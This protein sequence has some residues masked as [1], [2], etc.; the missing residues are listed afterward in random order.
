MQDFF[1]RLFSNTL[2]FVFAF[3][4]FMGILATFLS[5]FMNNGT[6]TLI[7]GVLTIICFLVA[8]SIPSRR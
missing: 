3:I 8:Y 7:L 2:S 1:K 5:I 6:V 4:G